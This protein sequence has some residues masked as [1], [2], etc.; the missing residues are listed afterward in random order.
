MS[1]GIYKKPGGNIEKWAV[2]FRGEN[3]QRDN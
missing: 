2:K 1:V 3:C